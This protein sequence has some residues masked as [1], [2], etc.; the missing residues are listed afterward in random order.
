[1]RIAQLAPLVESVPPQLYGG[2]ERVVSA[3]TE[4]LVQAGHDVTLYASGDSQTSARLV[5]IVDSALRLHPTYKDALPHHYCLIER[6][7]RENAPYDVIH[8][9]IDY[10]FFPFSRRIDIPVVTTLHGC[11]D[12]PDLPPLYDEYRDVGVVS[13]SDSQRVPLPQA[14]WLGTVYHG[15]SPANF[16][17]HER[18]EE[19]EHVV[20]LGRISREK[21]P[22]AAIRAAQQAKIPLKIAAKVDDADVAF[23]ESEIKPLLDHPGVEFVGEVGDDRKCDFVGKAL[24]LLFLIDWQEPFGL[25]MIE[26]LACGTPV[27][28]RPCGSVPEIIR[29]GVTG[30]L[31]DTV[32]DA[33]AALGRIHEIDRRECRRDFEERFSDA[34]MM[35]DYLRIYKR[36][37]A[38]RSQ[39]LI[40]A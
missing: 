24:A 35:R 23:F 31:V 33:V 39:S 6:L 2:T 36:A 26:S 15:Y 37:I 28:A 22:D 18:P 32:D 11:L 30:F 16:S 19:P 27:I 13:I 7:L 10:I 21:G 20:F 29:D 4:A 8:S 9:H 5:P 12:F 14:N 1:M 34:R 25:V 38:E 3:L 17:F 40:V